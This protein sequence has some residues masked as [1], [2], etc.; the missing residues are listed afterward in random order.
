[1]LYFDTYILNITAPPS[2][3]EMGIHLNQSL[4]YET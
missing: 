3:R 4:G 2:T 1:M